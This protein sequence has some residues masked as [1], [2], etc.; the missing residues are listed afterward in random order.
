MPAGGY[1]G[2]VDFRVAQASLRTQRSLLVVLSCPADAL[3]PADPRDCLAP[4]AWTVT[5]AVLARVLPAEED[6]ATPTELVLELDADPAPGATISVA[7]APLARSAYGQPTATDAVSLVAPDVLGIATQ[8]AG[9]A[10]ADL[11][12]PL[13]AGPQGDLGMVGQLA[14]LRAEIER[15]VT[16]PRGAFAHLP[17]FG[18]YA[19]PK[20]SYSR[21]DVAQRAA[22]IAAE[23]RKNPGVRT[24]YVTG[25]ILPS[26]LLRFDIEVV[27]SFSSA[28]ISLRKDVQ[29]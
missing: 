20:R 24:A 6:T 16:T 5:G 19:E 18:E 4:G 28:P 11:A 29:T 23:L 7:L 15:E 14:A 22:A 26:H 3:D 17:D 13:A 2:P 12:L 8:R 10:G 9:T 25:K 27:P 21:A 1:S